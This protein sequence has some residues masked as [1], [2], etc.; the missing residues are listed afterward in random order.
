[1]AYGKEDCSLKSLTLNNGS[2]IAERLFYTG[3]CHYR[4]EEYTQSAILWKQLADMDNV[5]KEYKKSQVDVL[6]N[7]GYLMFFGL[8]VDKDQFKAIAYWKKAITLGQTESEY[9]LCHAYADNKE[10]TYNREKAQMYCAKALLVYRGMEPR[11]EQIL[12]LVE[13]YYEQVK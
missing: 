8:G 9:H 1:M 6:N 5:D 4:N 11:N 12:S 2:N 7:P 10:P 13:G 3:T